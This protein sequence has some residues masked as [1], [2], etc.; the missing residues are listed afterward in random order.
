[1][2]EPDIPVDPKLRAQ[3]AWGIAAIYIAFF[4]GLV[5]WCW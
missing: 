2:N 3:V 4:G 5:W 1:M